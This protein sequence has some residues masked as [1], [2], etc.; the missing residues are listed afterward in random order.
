M[1]FGPNPVEC[2]WE[3]PNVSDFKCDNCVFGYETDTADGATC[4]KPSEFRPYRGWDS[5]THR[6][7]LKLQGGL[8]ANAADST[9]TTLILSKGFAYEIEAPDLE[10]KHAKF[11]GFEEPA[12]KINYELDFL[13]GAEV[14]I[15]CGV[16]ALGDGSGD[17]NVRKVWF[18]KPCPPFL[19][20][21]YIS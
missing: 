4:I 1:S 13:L 7:K 16:P 17:P 6:S 2:V 10:P 19:N 21:N 11:V 5:S 12:V 15:G 8:V 20:L 14:D 3:G 18:L 9:N